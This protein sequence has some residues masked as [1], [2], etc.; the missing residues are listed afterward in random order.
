M[1]LEGEE[2]DD[3][4]RIAN[5]NTCNA[6]LCRTCLTTENPDRCILC[7]DESSDEE[8]EPEVINRFWYSDPTAAETV[9]P[10]KQEMDCIRTWADHGFKQVLHTNLSKEEIAKMDF[11]WAGITQ[12][13]PPTDLIIT[14][15]HL[16]DCWQFRQVGWCVDF[17]V[18]LVNPD[19]LPK[20]TTFISSEFVKTTGG[21]CPKEVVA[22]GIRCH[23]GMT[24]FPKDCPSAAA[25]AEALEARLPKLDQKGKES[26][27]WMGNTIEAQRIL[28]DRLGADVFG[29]GP[30][31]TNPYPMW[32][33]KGPMGRTL[34]GTKLPDLEECAQKTA[35]YNTWTGYP[36][37]A[38]ELVAESFN[39]MKLP[40]MSEEEE[41]SE[42]E[43][44]DESEAVVCE[45]CDSTDG[46]LV[47]KQY[48][49]MDMWLC[50][51]CIKEDEASEEESSDES[52]AVVCGACD[53]TDGPE[54][55]ASEPP[56][57]EAPKEEA[58]DAS[59][60]INRFWY[61]DPTA[62]E[63]VLPSKQEMDCIRT[64]ADHGFKQVLHTNLSKEEIA[65]MDFQWA[66]IT[67]YKPPTD[68]I[69]TPQHL[70][71][72]WQFRQVGWCVD[73]DVKLV[74]PDM[75]P[76]QTTF[77]SSEFVKTTGGQCPKEV[78]ASGIRCHLGM[79]RFPKDCPSAAAIAEALEARLPKLDQKG[80]ESKEWMGNTIEAQ[81]ILLDRL[82]A[83]VFGEGPI[84]TNPYPMWFTKGPMG[85][86]LFGTKLPD[87]EE[88]AQKTACYN[89]WTGYPKFAAE[90]VAE[91]F[92]KMKLPKMSEEEESS[93]EES[94]DESEAVVCEA[95]DSTDGPLVCKQY[96]CMDMWLCQSCIKEDES[97][98]PPTAEAP[99]TC[100]VA[101]QTERM[102]RQL[103]PGTVT[104][105]CK[106]N[107]MDQPPTCK[108]LDLQ[109]SW[110]I[111]QCTTALSGAFGIA[112][113]QSTKTSGI[114]LWVRKPNG[115]QVQ[116]SN[117]HKKLQTCMSE[118]K[119][120]SGFE[121]FMHT[122]GRGGA[123]KV[124]KTAVKK[125]KNA[126]LTEMKNNIT[127]KLGTV[128]EAIR[129]EPS[130]Q[131]LEQ[132]MSRFMFKS[133]EDAF[134]AMYDILKER[135][136]H[137]LNEMHRIIE[138]SGSGNFQNKLNLINDLFWGSTVTNCRKTAGELINILDASS[139]MLVWAFS[140]CQEND[141]HFNMTNFKQ[142][143]RRVLAYKEG[144]AQG[145]A[146]GAVQ[147]QTETGLEA[148]MEASR[149]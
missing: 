102:A 11:Q 48:G 30:I 113:H 36:K 111:A 7:K 79:T 134:E 50:Q 23:L 77:I 108:E 131:L 71:D 59:K 132:Q 148:P 44:S 117:R 33:T 97:S 37:F 60:V 114:S 138:E 93:E 133:E 120:V 18:K 14:P 57:A 90:L 43:S 81:R 29:E 141:K 73:F 39:K 24:R 103:A 20:Q 89:T 86:T 74:N 112:S 65:K 146:H 31:V 136:V 52:E 75:L 145:Q 95:C 17:D 98:E 127:E 140:K 109:V 149:I 63:T 135:S 101:V 1:S 147:G 83:D 28:L 107:I 91:S 110:T 25:I 72:C 67:Q 22:S 64:W 130:M 34:F 42:E 121:S 69:I 10:S 47:C 12:Y 115:E 82:G 49:C 55:E 126:K 16:K 87:L 84:V 41:S 85:R 116:L 144:A 100:D 46:P 118:L 27:E 70:K 76:K 58:P 125:D 62:A 96:G 66:G 105:L 61:S 2:E 128:G 3:E 5:C 26:K 19:M 104:T 122:P 21:Q 51:S 92:N 35:C 88:C 53:S 13:K 40:K 106:M 137:D 68:L 56:T 129:S 9:L 124:R 94:S 80:K 45:A 123:P 78:V 32:F 143:I 139:N 99:L 142:E 119:L 15:Q 54:D 4:L 8:E 38:A 6:L